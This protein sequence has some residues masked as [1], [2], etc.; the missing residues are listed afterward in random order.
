MS[1]M[2]GTQALIGLLLCG[3]ASVAQSAVRWAA[4]GAAQP[5]VCGASVEWVAHPDRPGIAMLWISG[6]PHGAGDYIYCLKFARG[7]MMQPEADN[8]VRCMRV[9]AGLW[10]GAQGERFEPTRLRAYGPGARVRLAANRHYYG[11]AFEGETVLEFRAGGG[12][13]LSPRCDAP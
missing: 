12:E 3:C 6:D 4:L 9:I 1:R 13:T 2:R 7:A 11:A 8:D 5:E 10:H